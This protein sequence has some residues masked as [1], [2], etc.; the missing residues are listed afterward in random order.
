MT[1]KHAP[2]HRIDRPTQG[3]QN[4]F[5]PEALEFFPTACGVSGA[6][7][8]VY[9]IQAFPPT[10]DAGW[11]TPAANLPGVTVSLHARPQDAANMIKA[12][13][14]RIGGLAGQLAPPHTARV[15][16][17]VTVTMCFPP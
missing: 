8:R 3:L 11:L 16:N 1:K 5:A 7:A 6:W 14:R 17:T 13:N 9:M 2:E 10:V 4:I 12:L 15:P